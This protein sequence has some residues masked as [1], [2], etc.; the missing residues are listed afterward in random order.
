ML[1]CSGCH[2]PDGTGVPGT[3]PSL[4][5]IGALLDRAGG[6]R[7]LASVPGVAQAPLDDAA[8]AALLD[9]VIATW[10]DAPPSPPYA[11][12]EI[13]RLRA[14][15]LRDPVAARAALDASP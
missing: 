13:A 15:P 5:G 4:H 12:E 11:A 8:L 6:R 3:T 10:S 7:Y 2:R 9:W 1:H 14:R